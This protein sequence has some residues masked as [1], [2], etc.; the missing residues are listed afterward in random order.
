MSKRLK[1]V[2]TIIISLAL[3]A[4]LVILLDNDIIPLDVP[5]TGGP[6]PDTN[7]I[8]D[9]GGM[10]EASATIL[11]LTS[12]GYLLGIRFGVTVRGL[13]YQGLGIALVSASIIVVIIV[14]THIMWGLCCGDITQSSYGI[15]LIVTGV[16]LAAVVYGYFII[17]LIPYRETLAVRMW[18][19]QQVTVQTLRRGYK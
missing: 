19:E 12:L 15:S 18:E 4:V 8:D 16:A 5:S 1:I 17:L 9:K 7:W 13:K 3:I 11:A 10:Y 6:P 14:Q 2:S